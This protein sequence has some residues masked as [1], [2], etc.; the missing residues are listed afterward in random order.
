MNQRVHEGICLMDHAQ[1]KVV[2]VPGSRI[3]GQRRGIHNSATRTVLKPTHGYA[4]LC[5]GFNYHG[6]VASAA[7]ARHG[8]VIAQPPSGWPALDLTESE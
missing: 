1:E 2:N 3:T 4:Q 6:A 7:G 8:A 5:Y